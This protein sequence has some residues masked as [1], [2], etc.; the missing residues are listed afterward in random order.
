M[1]IIFR[2][3]IPKNKLIDLPDDIAEY[4]ISTGMAVDK[5]EGYKYSNPGII[6]IAYKDTNCF[7]PKHHKDKDNEHSGHIISIPC[8]MDINRN[9]NQKVLSRKYGDCRGNRKKLGERF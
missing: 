9:Q 1:E 2:K 3:A 5:K 4:F 6:S 7:K 8:E